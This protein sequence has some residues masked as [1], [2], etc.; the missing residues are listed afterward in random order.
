MEQTASQSEPWP[1]TPHTHTTTL[2]PQLSQVTTA[3]DDNGATTTTVV[4]STGA[5]RQVP[6]ITNDVEAG[7]EITRVVMPT[8][9]V[10]AES[11]PSQDDFQSPITR[12]MSA[13]ARL[14]T[15]A[16]T[17]PPDRSLSNPVFTTEPASR[18]HPPSP[19]QVDEPDERNVTVCIICQNE[20]TKMGSHRMVSLQCGHIYGRPCITKWLSGWG[21][22]DRTPRN[23]CP[24]CKQHATVRHIRPVFADHVAVRDNSEF[25]VLREKYTALLTEHRQKESD[26][27]QLQLS[28]GLLKN[29]MKQLERTLDQ[30]HQQNAHLQHMVDYRK[31]RGGLMDSSGGPQRLSR[32][33]S[34]SSSGIIDLTDQPASWFS[35]HESFL[36]CPE[37]RSCRVLSYHPP[38]EELLVS[39]HASSVRDMAKL[40]TAEDCLIRPTLSTADLPYGLLR[41]SLQDTRQREYVGLHHKPIRDIACC[42][43]NTKRVLTTGLD[44]T[45]KILSTQT[46]TI[47][48]SYRL[49][50]PGWSCTWFPTSEYEF[51]VGLSSGE[52][53]LFDTRVTGQPVAKLLTTQQC[54]TPIHSLVVVLG[55]CDGDSTQ[56]C[57]LVIA[58]STEVILFRTFPNPGVTTTSEDPWSTLKSPPGYACYSVSYDNATTQLLVSYRNTLQRTILH[59]VYQLCRSV[60]SDAKG[61]EPD[62][63]ASP[64]T[65]SSPLP[66]LFITQLTKEPADGLPHTTLS[67]AWD[68]VCTME[69]HGTQTNLARSSIVTLPRRDTPTLGS[70]DKD[71]MYHSQSTAV[72]V[73]N[74]ATAA[75]DIWLVTPS[76][77][78]SS[79]REH[80]SEVKDFFLDTKFCPLS[81]PSSPGLLALLSSSQLCLYRYQSQCST[82]MKEVI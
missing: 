19:T 5:P 28:Y 31:F 3:H 40:N 8:T 18:S 44:K 74:N 56:P 26:Y 62:T 2:P 22:R 72:V 66:R 78:Q 36:I 21:T 61:D 65:S 1:E 43:H 23:T 42:P 64:P 27:V 17:R 46:N 41:L 13:V 35:L 59:H 58:G 52:V 79:P 47:V 80:I 51:L 82:D 37:K 34:G 30:L 29:S 68:P 15:H 71:D 39:I 75:V 77:L 53:L 50:A 12:S 38:A 14:A 33:G 54:C 20:I 10:P 55:H 7:L 25:E 60:S 16:V 11:S 24:T 73:P 67:L 9:S 70:T 6:P 48:Q 69:Y 76:K 81:G 49:P 45:A 57:P 32:R 63:E 4:A